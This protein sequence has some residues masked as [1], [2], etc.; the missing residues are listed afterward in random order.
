MAEIIVEKDFD[1]IKIERFIKRVYP[2]LP[3]SLIFKLLRKG[4]VRVNKKKITHNF[5]VKEGDSII[6]HVSPDL[7]SESIK[8]DNLSAGC[9]LVDLDI[10]FE[11]EDFLAIN[12]PPGFAVH[13]GVGHKEDVLL[14]AI[15]KY[16][17]YEA[18]PLKFP[19]TPVH[20]LDIETSGVLIFAKNYEFLRIFNDL[21]RGHR[22]YK[23]YIALVFG[24]L[25]EE[26]RE[27]YAPVIRKDRPMRISNN[28]VGRSLVSRLAISRKFESDSK[29]FTLLKVIIK[30]G[31][32]HQIRSHLSQFGFPLVGDK[33]YG[34]ST[35]NRWAKETFGLRRQ[36]LHAFETKFEYNGSAYSLRALLKEDLLRVLDM[37]DINFSQ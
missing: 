22:I 16:L 11:N 17:R 3:M 10:I 37:L 19:P 29:V 5:R 21:Q 23:E 33:L 35:I 12:K 1:G 4:K 28:K 9:E 14:G 34:D 27:I 25:S 30:T 13:G 26:K 32:T 20:R 15:Y 6:L 7:L 24:S 2:K 31:R 8:K 18:S 36:F